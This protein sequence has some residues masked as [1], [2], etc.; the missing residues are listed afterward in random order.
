MTN[1]FR[2]QMFLGYRYIITAEL[3]KKKLSEF[4]LKLG[5]L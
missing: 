3:E 1:L 5:K 4:Y 2:D